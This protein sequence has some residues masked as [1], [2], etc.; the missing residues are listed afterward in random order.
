MDHGR[1][2]RDATE[3]CE[4]VLLYVREIDCFQTELSVAQ[5]FYS[6]KIFHE[7]IDLHSHL[8]DVQGFVKC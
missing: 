5:L 1:P 7:N 3:K 4:S 6:N 2:T 8:I